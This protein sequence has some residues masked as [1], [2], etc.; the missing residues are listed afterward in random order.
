MGADLGRN[1]RRDRIGNGGRFESRPG[2]AADIAR[3]VGRYL[4]LVR[5]PPHARPAPAPNT[6]HALWSARMKF[7]EIKSVATATGVWATSLRCPSSRRQLSGSGGQRRFIWETDGRGEP[8]FRLQLLPG[9]MD[10]TPII[11]ETGISGSSMTINSL[12]GGSY[13][14]RVGM[15]R[16]VDGKMQEVWTDPETLQIGP[17]TSDVGK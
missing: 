17:K 10:T 15:R 3:R 2:Y 6:L 1:L 12:P 16:V 14:W 4:Q 9:S 5:L 7:K 11:D 13:V 8:V